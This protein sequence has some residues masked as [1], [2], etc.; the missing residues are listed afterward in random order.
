MF[1]EFQIQSFSTF[2]AFVTKVSLMIQHQGSPN[3][4]SGQHQNGET[5][6]PRWIEYGQKSYM[7][8]VDI[9]MYIY[10]YISNLMHVLISNIQ[11]FKHYSLLIVL[12]LLTKKTPS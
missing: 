9:F 1:H 3:L 2:V 7:I 12:T 8:F 5:S 11:I 4:G 6:G 10:I